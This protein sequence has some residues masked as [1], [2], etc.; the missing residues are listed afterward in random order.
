[1]TTRSTWRKGLK[2][3]KWAPAAGAVLVLLS[4][5][6][7]AN[8][9]AAALPD[10]VPPHQADGLPDIF[11]KHCTSCHNDIDKAADV[12]GVHVR[13]DDGVEALDA[14][15]AERRLDGVGRA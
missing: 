15:P 14:E 13:G 3:P 10:P 6:A 12:V 11:D 7:H 5:V 1:M 9:G 4:A 2:L 8:G